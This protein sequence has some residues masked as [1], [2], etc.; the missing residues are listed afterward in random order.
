MEAS[1]VIRPRRGLVGIVAA[2]AW[3]ASREKRTL[4]VASGEYS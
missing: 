3:R 4:M 1:P 2:R